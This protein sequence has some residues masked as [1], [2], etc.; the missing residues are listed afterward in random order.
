MVSTRTSIKSQSWG[1]RALSGRRTELTFFALLAVARVLAAAPGSSYTGTFAADDDKRIFYF[2]LSQAGAVTLQTWSYAGGLNAA[3]DNIPE[4]GFDPTLSV[5]DANGNLIAVNQDGGCGTV[6]ADSVTSFCWDS[7]LSLTLPAGNYSAVLTQSANLPNGPTLAQSFAYDPS[8]CVPASPLVCPTDAQGVFTA[9]PGNAAPG[10]WDFFPSKRTANYAVDIVGSTSTEIT[11]ITSSTTLPSGF[12]DNAYPGFQF[13]AQSGPQ[14]TLS[15]S[16]VSGTLPPGLTLNAATGLLSGTGTVPG[17]YRFSVQVTDGF[18]PAASVQ[19]SVSILVPPPPPPALTISVSPTP[20]AT[21]VG[22]SVTASF[23]AS[24]GTGGYKFTVSGLP[25]GVTVSGSGLSGTATQAGTV[26]ATVTV[27]DS[28]G[29][30]AI[31]SVTIDVLGLTTTSLAG[32]MIGQP[33]GVTLGATGGAGAYT[34][35]ATG[36][37]SGISLS[38]AGSMG[39]TPKTAGTFPV[40]VSVSSGGVTATGS[41]S[42]TIAKATPVM[43]SSATLPGGKVSVQYSQGFSA[44]GG[45]P[46]YTWALSSGTLP[47]GL[48]LNSAGIVSGAPTAAGNYAFGIMATDTSGGIATAAASISIQAAPLQLSTM[49]LPS[50]MF[51]VPYPMQQLTVNG[52][53]A[54]FTFAVTSGALPPGLTLSS[55]GVLSGT[56]QS[57][58]NTSSIRAALKKRAADSSDSFGVAVTVTDAAGTQTTVQIPLSIRQP[59]ADL[60]LTQGTLSFALANPASSAPAP[61]VVG[62]QSTDPTQII[63]YTLVVNPSVPWLNVTNGS[64]TPDSIQASITSAGLTLAPGTYNT[65][66]T[67]TCTSSTCSGDMLSIAVTLTVT[68]APPLLQ[69]STNLLSFATTNTST[70]TLSGSINVSNAGGG[71]LG[72]AAVSCEAGY[73][74]AGAAPQNLAGGVSATIPVTINPFG[75]SAGF[76]RTQVDISTSGGMMSVPV[77]LFIS[78]NAT[79]ALA[80]S[81]TQFNQLQGSAP[82]NPFGSFLVAV[83]STSPVS[84]NASIA[85]IQ[86]VAAASWLVLQTGG[87]AASSSQPG[88]VI[89]AID[90]AAAAQLPAGVYYA[91]IQV[92]SSD[93]SNSPQDYEVVL[94]VAPVNTPVAPEP[95]PA[96]LLFIQ[97]G[98]G[99]PA[100]QVVNVYSASS[101]PATY[102]ASASTTTGGNWLSVTPGTG[103]SSSAV[104][105]VS[106]VSVDTS[107]LGPGV[108]YGGVS[109]SLSATAVRTVNVTLI[110]PSAGAATTSAK[111]ANADPRAV[112]CTPSKLVPA[113]TGLVNSFSQPAGWPTPLAINLA[114]DC[115]NLI[116]NGRIVASFTNGDPPL[117]LPLADPATA[118]YSGTWAPAHPSSQVTININASALGFQNTTS[119]INGAVPPNAVPVI[120]PNATLHVF[121]PLVGGALA[122]GTIIAIYGNFLATSTSSATTIPLPTLYNDASVTIGNFYAPIYYASPTQVNVQVPFELAPGQQYERLRFRERRSQY[123]AA[124]SALGR[125]A[126]TCRVRERRAHRAASGGRIAD[127]GDFAGCA[128]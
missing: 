101:Q 76:F 47:S 89:F 62:I 14:A 95:Q 32:G 28:G 25:A 60:I 111:P 61:Q 73:C 12:V 90:P 51:G 4:G 117:I 92:S 58:G 78:A 33:Y 24:G 17:S 5:F 36:L 29:D 115:G 54:P 113:Q 1:N 121:D 57:G 38:S 19:V 97:S 88:S 110:I 69:V 50:G 30:T 63:S 66:I 67:A 100:P 75:L 52:G 26:I 120:S 56:P 109:Y 122:P 108:Y 21:S 15:W 81:G 53:V 48:S 59:A 72:F 6:A 107:M 64:M 41:L 31:T 43:I 23:N 2:S 126:G 11:G 74:T 39:G 87:G 99:L 3:G 96:G 86:N 93:V 128:R 103:S 65:S 83:N 40:S 55:D 44:T 79:L 46:P 45:V 94:N 68:A 119:R 9:A 18:Q 84:F 105:G 82:G 124:D 16:V 127:Y 112:S 20:V 71:T 13:T 98:N 102:Q 37:P 34:F 118:L 114:D 106:T 35:A 42:L 123:A 49:T 27:T 116:G 7:Y 104:P 125:R 10:F 22:G 77:T 70:G 8:L 91:I 80:P 85:S